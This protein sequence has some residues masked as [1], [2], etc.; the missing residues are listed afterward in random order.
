MLSPM[1]RPTLQEAER[2]AAWVVAHRSLANG[3][4][5]HGEHDVA[6]PYLGDTLSMGQGF[7]ALYEVTGDREWLKRAEAARRFIAANFAE[8][9]GAGFVTSKILYRPRLQ[10]TSGTR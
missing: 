2:S 9:R 3:G 5:S 6:G 4:F 7:L 10:T 8:A 1:T